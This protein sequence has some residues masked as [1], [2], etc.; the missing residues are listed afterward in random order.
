LGQGE[1]NAV[2]ENKSKVLLVTTKTSRDNRTLNIYLNNTHLEQVSKLKYLGIYVNSRLS[3]D[4]H[5]DYVA[6]KCTLIA[7]MLEKSA[8]LKWSMGHRALKVIYSGATEPILKYG[9]PAW[10]KAL[11]KNNLRKYH[12]CKE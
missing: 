10:E 12:K 1:Q 3:F 11:K 9:A 8:K 7:K 4:R 6:E 5:I 2:N